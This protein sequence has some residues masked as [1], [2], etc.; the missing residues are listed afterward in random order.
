MVA[1]LA[2]FIGYAWF[3]RA[4]VEDIRED[5]ERLATLYARAL[6]VTSAE[7]AQLLLFEEVIQSF[8]YPVI[9]TDELGN[10]TAFKNLDLDIENETGPWSPAD[11]LATS[12][13]CPLRSRN[14]LNS[15]TKARFR[16]VD[17][18]CSD[19]TS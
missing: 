19:L 14:C 15:G 12:P 10:P 11:R 8:P 16:P 7:D 18:A 1:Y 6:S 4:L 5:T 3:T 2:L 17:A 9:L 13:R